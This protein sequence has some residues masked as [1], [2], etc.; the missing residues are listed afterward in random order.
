MCIKGASVPHK[1]GSVIG[2]RMGNYEEENTSNMES[3]LSTHGL[4][5]VTF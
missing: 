1:A 5:K 3:V 4:T 2:P